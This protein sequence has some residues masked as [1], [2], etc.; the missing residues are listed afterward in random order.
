MIKVRYDPW[1]QLIAA[2]VWSP[3]LLTFGRLKYFCAFKNIFY[4]IEHILHG[5][6]LGLVAPHL[7]QVEPGPVCLAGARG[8]GGSVLGL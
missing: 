4:L 8:H 7:G 5:Q 6:V 2:A 3:A 1:M